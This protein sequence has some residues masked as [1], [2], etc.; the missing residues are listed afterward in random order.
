MVAGVGVAG[1]ESQ[2][3]SGV[4]SC[5]DLVGSAKAPRASTAGHRGCSRVTEEQ[6]RDTT[7]TTVAQPLAMW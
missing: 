5:L 4:R 3:L 1:S 2:E 6:N 7:Q